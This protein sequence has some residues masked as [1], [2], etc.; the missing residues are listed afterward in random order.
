MTKKITK[1]EL[2]EMLQHR[3]FSDILSIYNYMFDKK[4]EMVND[5]IGNHSEKKLTICL[6]R[7]GWDFD[8]VSKKK[9]GNLN[10]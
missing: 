9:G 4:I 1:D 6:K 5:L 7:H 10:D 8:V 3:F 2:R